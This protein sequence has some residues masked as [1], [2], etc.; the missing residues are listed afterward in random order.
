ME[1]GNDMGVYQI[2]NLR[3][4]KRYIGSSIHM[5]RRFKEHMNALEKNKHHTMKLQRSY[6]K[7][8]DK[9]CYKF[10]VL[11]NVAE[12]KLLKIREQF[13]IDYF[14]SFN[15]GYNCTEIVDDPRY[16]LASVRKAKAKK[17]LEQLYVEFLSIYDDK[18]IK[19]GYT[20]G[21]RLNNKHYKNAAMKKLIKIIQWFNSS[22]ETSTFHLKIT[23]SGTTCWVSICDDNDNPYAVCKYD[24]NGLTFS[25]FDTEDKIASLKRAGVYDDEKYTLVVARI[26]NSGL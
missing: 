13:Y 11:E 15:K 26:G 14:D 24:K 1:Y 19:I 6:N 17:E 9:S 23:Y 7:S 8:K 3:N 18:F 5:H 16:A 21:Q 22:F 12:E 2:Q 4:G 25:T 10:S 20:M